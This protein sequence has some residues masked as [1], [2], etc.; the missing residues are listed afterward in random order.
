MNQRAALP[1]PPLREPTPA[2][3]LTSMA[4]ANDRR[5]FRRVMALFAV[6]TV[7]GGVI[8][9]FAPLGIQDPLFRQVSSVLLLAG[10][11]DTLVLRFWDRLFRD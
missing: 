11:C 3:S 8:I 9:G 6:S 1:D 7:V 5:A 4:R 10:I 2:T